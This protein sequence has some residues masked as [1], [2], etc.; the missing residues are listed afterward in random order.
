MKIVK[1][2]GEWLPR[3]IPAEVRPIL[4]FT[5]A[6]TAL[7]AGSRELAGRGWDYLCEHLYGWERLGVV[8]AVG[9][10]AVFE[11]WYYPHIA[12]FAVPG[13]VVAWCLAAWWITPPP[14]AEHAPIV[15]ASA[16]ADAFLPWLLDLIGDRP[17]IHLRD[18]YPAM[19]QLPGHEDRDNTQLRAA[20]RTLDI[21]IRRSLRLGGVAGRSGVAVADLRALP[22]PAGESSGESDGDAGQPAD[23]PAGESAGEQLEST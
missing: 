1:K 5:G 20:L 23:S 15:K 2:V 11:C 9:Y 3:A 6:G 22:S 21:P 7:L 19:R 10:V 16:P 13:A 12:R 18:L 14:T 4:A 8:A 17:G